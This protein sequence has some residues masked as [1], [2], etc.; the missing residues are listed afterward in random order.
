MRLCPRAIVWLTIGALACLSGAPVAAQQARPGAIEK[1]P[2]ATQP[3]TDE[4]PASEDAAVAA[5]LATKPTTPVECVRAAK[6]LA[7]LGHLNVAKRFLKQAIDAKLDLPQL[8]ALGEKFGAAT[9]LDLASRSALLPEAKQLADAVV[10][11]VRARLQ[12]AT[13]IEKLIQQLQD[14]QAQRRMEALAGLQEAGRAAIGPLLAVLADPTRAAEQANVRTVLAGMGRTARQPLIAALDAA[15]PKLKVQTILTL[16]EMNDRKVAV[17]L[18]LPCVSEK[19][20]AEVRAAAAAALKQLTRRAPTRPEAVALLTD[21]AKSYFARRE[22]IEDVDNGKVELWSWGQQKRQCVVHSGT[23]ADVDRALAARY[24]RDAYALAPD[25]RQLRLMYL[26][27]MLDSAAY[28]N[29]LDRPLDLQNTAVVEAKRFG[30]KAIDES[31]AFAIEHGHPAAAAAAAALLGEIGDADELLHQG[32]ERAPLAR[33]LQQPDRRLRMAALKVIVRLRPST[34]F[35]GS[36]DVPLALGFFAASSGVR[37]A[38][39]AGANIEQSRDLAGMLAAAG[40]QTD[41]AAT[42]KELLR[43]ATRSPDYEFVWIDVSISRPVI[44]TLLQELRQDPRTANLGVGLVARSGNFELAEELARHD[45]L[46]KA[47][48]RPHDEQSLRWQLDQLTALAPAEFVDN[49][50]RQ[51]QASEA[52]DLLA[53]LS[54]SSGKLYDLRRVQDSVLAAIQ[55]PKLAVKAVAVLAELNSAE[56]QRTLLD[57]ASR[58]THPL[59]LRKAAAGAFCQNREKHGLLLTTV[60]IHEQYRR[61]N[62]SESQDAATQQ[63]L[64]LI[65]DSF[66]V[67]APTKPSNNGA[68]A[69]SQATTPIPNP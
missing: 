28:A 32:A 47:F 34:P 5:I 42:G 48:A 29:G 60:E 54:R 43:L 12:D 40:L 53:E 2:T 69:R 39:V 27:T 25:D 45:P 44:G 59:A 50:V 62:E 36:S 3:A 7:D 55:N 63:I 4:Q 26:T 16:A 52:L 33:A 37:H 24:A 23:P 6:N 8:A 1:Q 17:D 56:S 61:Y 10:P 66:E 46:A 51:Q 19:S 41:T 11:V 30:S 21:A 35:P 13:R 64:G 58:F 49:A 14:P 31:L 67:S 57:V 20:D 18:L 65:L 9:F 38:L 22:P 68:N 15:D